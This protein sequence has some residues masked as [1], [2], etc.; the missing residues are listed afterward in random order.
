MY[1][2]NWFFGAACGLVC[3]L[4]GN[5]LAAASADE[6][7][8]LG[9]RTRV[10]IGTSDFGAAVPMR[11]LA[12]VD[13]PVADHEYRLFYQFRLHIKKGEIGLVLG[14]A[15][16]PNGKA[17][18]LGVLANPKGESAFRYDRYYYS[19]PHTHSPELAKQ[20]AQGVEI[21]ESTDITRK[22]LRNEPSRN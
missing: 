10:T 19:R 1:A 7:E 5:G 14:D 3:V 20:D 4:Q 22:E 18:T 2:C 12:R 16:M 6:A 8:A 21:V 13:H 9:V 15:V 11:L 17:F